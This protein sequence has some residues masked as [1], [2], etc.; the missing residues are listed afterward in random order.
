M[1]AQN[2]TTGRAHTRSA[3]R[4]VAAAA[5]NSSLLSAA[6]PSRHIASGTS[7]TTT[8]HPNVGSALANGEVGS[9]MQR[10]QV[11][12]PAVSENSSQQSLSSKN[13]RGLSIGTARSLMRRKPDAAAEHTAEHTGA[14]QPRQ[15]AAAAGQTATYGAGQHPDEDEEGPRANMQEDLLLPPGVPQG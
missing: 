15:Q 10:K 1:Q 11:P 2:A 5:L 8:G 7:G 14:P 13:R 9:H 4:I 3:S 12:R 6:G